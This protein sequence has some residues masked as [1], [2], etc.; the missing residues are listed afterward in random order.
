MRFYLCALCCVLYSTAVFSQEYGYTHY[1]SK[2][3]LAGSTVY[4][5]VQDK[6]GFLWFGTEGGLSRFDGTH[7]KNFTKEDGLPDNEV[8]QLF[9]DSKGRVWIAP[10]KKSVCYYYKGKIHTPANDPL[11]QRIPASDFIVRFAEDK[12]GNILMQEVRKLHLVETNGRVT[13]TDSI[14][15]EPI[16]HVSAICAGVDGG[17]M[18]MDRSRL[19][20]YR[21]NRFQLRETIPSYNGHF[22]NYAMEPGL[23]VHCRDIHTSEIKFFKQDRS[24]IFSVKPNHIR[25]TII[26]DSLVGYCLTD[27]A[28]I[29]NIN[30]SDSPRHFLKDLP[31]NGIVKDREGNT[32]FSTFGHGVYKLSSQHVLNVRLRNDNLPAQVFAFAKYKENLL[33]GTEIN[34]LY[35]LDRRTG[36]PQTKKIRLLYRRVDEV[37]S[38]HI[39]NGNEI[40]C[41]SSS[42]LFKLGPDAK[43][44]GSFTSVVKGMF[45]YANKLY[46]ATTGAVLVVD[47][48]TFKITDTAWPQRSTAVFVSNDTVYIGTLNGLYCRLPNRTFRFLGERT[49]ALAVRITAI[50]K[51]AAGVLW[52]GTYGDG[53]IG[54]KNDRVV[55]TL[56][57]RT[58]LTSNVCRAFYLQGNY[59]WIGTDK[60]I[61]KINIARADHPITKY[62]TG[63]GLVTDIINALYVE[64]HNVF[65]GTPEGYTF[66]DEQKIVSQS[67]CDLLFT[68][69]T[70]GG[71]PCSPDSIPAVIAHKKNSIRFDYAGISFRSNGDIRYLSLIHI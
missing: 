61:N 67:R 4:C 17:F 2:D 64:G 12:A 57:R 69:V 28:I 31:V 59:L 35:N 42:A 58:G 22:S 41:G 21:N 40:I 45:P 14:N 43:E 54:Y 65:A 7:F 9:A 8:I 39:Y 49:P 27:G 16:V 13:V 68:D 50:E 1:D 51:D 19:F 47:P 3:G 24:F 53:L 26:D 37:N 11:L 38:L 30:G 55:A 6:D 52:I 48:E 56:T 29:Y 10:F 70:I 25:Y 18:V 34:V 62:T 23:L 36:R 5:M 32:W 15:S 33:A 46:V 66:F 20:D 60:G 44:N 63:D 71:E